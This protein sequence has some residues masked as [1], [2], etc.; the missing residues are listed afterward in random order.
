MEWANYPCDSLRLWSRLERLVTA[1][2]GRTP[3]ADDA[4]WQRKL[5]DIG[6]FVGTPRPAG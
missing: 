2:T 1:T 4:E 5:N 6:I 3:R